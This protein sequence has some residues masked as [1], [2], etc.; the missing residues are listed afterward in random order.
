M[1][2]LTSSLFMLF[3]MLA[4]PQAHSERLIF[5]MG[6]KQGAPTCAEF[7]D[8]WEVP[9]APAAIM[10]IAGFGREV[11]AAQDCV[12]QNNVAMACQHW[13]KLLPVIDKTGAALEGQRSDIEELIR[14]NSCE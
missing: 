4:I 7:Y 5:T 9:G 11:V 6:S 12:K 3:T 10:A 14:Q 13:R 1:L 8:K 2:R